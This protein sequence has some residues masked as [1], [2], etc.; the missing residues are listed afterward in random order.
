M[1]FTSHQIAAWAGF[2]FWP[3][4]RILALIGTVPVLSHRSIPLRAKV[5][6]GVAIAL[7]LAPTIPTP[8]MEATLDAVFFETLVRNILIG[9]ALGFAIRILFSGIELAGQM[10][11]LQ[12]G[13]SF[14]GFFNPEAADMDNPV[15]N[16]VSLLVLLLFLAIDG[17]LMVLYGLRQSFEIFPIAEA[18]PRTLAFDAIAGMGAQVFSIALSISLPVLAV[19]L[20]INV[21]LGVMA[22]VSPQL[23]LFAIGFPITLSAGMVVLFLF[24]P[25]LEAPIRATL[26]RALS[27]WPAG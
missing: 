4:V 1:L 9:T 5:A 14:G 19:M 8:A 26:E 16:F 25:H 18:G 11:G 10:V 2:I 22:R 23:H 7:V 3:L 24:V 17:H 13:L 6:I 21:V 27:V 12:V 15:A 20:L